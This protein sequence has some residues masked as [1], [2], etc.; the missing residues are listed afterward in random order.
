MR[1]G[2]VGD[3]HRVD[4][5]E[6]PRQPGDD[7]P[8]VVGRC[9]VGD[10]DPVAERRDVP[11]HALRVDVLVVEEDDPDYVHAASPPAITG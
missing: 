8:R 7:L 4:V 2:R 1:P 10:V 3:S 11:D 6:L 9:V 5:V